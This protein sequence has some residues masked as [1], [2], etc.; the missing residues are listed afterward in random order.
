MPLHACPKS[1]DLPSADSGQVGLQASSE[2][3][4]PFEPWQSPHAKR[5]LRQLEVRGMRVN[6]IPV[7]ASM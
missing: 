1:I 7:S 3:M 6:P 4:T 2:L 5:L